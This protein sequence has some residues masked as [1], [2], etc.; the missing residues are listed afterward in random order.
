[1]KTRIGV[2]ILIV[3]LGAAAFTGCARSPQAKRDRHLAAGKKFLK[4]KNYRRAILEFQNALQAM[5][6]DAE[7]HYELGLALTESG[8]VQHG[9]NNI[10][11]AVEINPNNQEAQL[12]LAR[13]MASA[14]D[15]EVV[16]EGQNELKKL[17]NTSATP[18]VLNALALTQFKL[19]EVGDAVDSLQAALKN[20]P[21]EL[22]S[23]IML[24]LA[25]LTAKD[26]AGA[27]EVLKRACE[28]A[29][30]SADPHTVLGEFYLA[31]RRRPEA[32]AEFQKALQIDPK[33]YPA[34]L[35]LA[36]VQ[37]A[38]G[39]KQQA[40]ENFR[41]LANSGEKSYKPM[42]ALFLFNNGRQSEAVTELERLFKEDSSDRLTRTRLVLA[43]RAVHRDAD[44]ERILAQ[45]LKSN[46]HDTD[47]LTQRATLFQAS[48]K[49]TEAEKDLNEVLHVQPNSADAH[50]ILS[51]LRKAQGQALSERQELSETVTADPN[52]LRARIELAEE[53]TA[54]GDYK[55]ALDLLNQAPPDQRQNLLLVAERNWVLWAA[56]DMA[57]MRKGVD[58][59]LARARIPDLL[60]Q[61]G[62]WKVQAGNVPAGRLAFVEALKAAPDDVRAME[63]LYRSYA[64]KKETAVGLEKVKEYASRQPKSALMQEHLGML[65]LE[66]GDRIHARVAFNAAKAAD[67]TFVNAD[68]SLVQIDISERKLG[69]AR[70]RLQKILAADKRSSMAHLWLGIVDQMTDDRASALEEFRKSVEANAQNAQALNNLAYLLADYANKPDEALP[71]AEKARELSPSRA[72]YADTLGWVFYRKGIY[73]SAVKQMEAAAASQKQPDAVT[74][75]HLAMAYAKAGDGQK[76]REALQAALKLNPKLPEAQIAAGIVGELK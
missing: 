42:Y 33:K 26:P 8:D 62:L 2:L 1:M 40:E 61:D 53:L 4:D 21:R 47:A 7:G 5:P 13:I 34:L 28:S 41:R 9:F 39:E 50:Y 52:F 76:G 15:L 12:T 20:S 55:S 64:V 72:D 19:G 63:A 66:N 10:R 67:P 23:S 54:A 11:R 68:F 48:G 32:E 31:R 56:E 71:Y 69:D 18:D 73:T 30:G 51:K 6:G 35:E 70:D 45:A 74:E 24:A 44:A 27:E 43:Y 36:Q 46:P 16:R 3:G 59:G 38:S 17:A 75:Y 58:Q 37:N 60:I 22:G 57:E 49:Y 14:R 25:K 29:P 65:L